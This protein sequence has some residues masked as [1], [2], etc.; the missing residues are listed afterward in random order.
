MR[1]PMGSWLLL[2]AL[3]LGPMMSASAAEV[4][5]KPDKSGSDKATSEAGSDQS[6]VAK[7]AAEK[8]TTKTKTKKKGDPAAYPIQCSVTGGII[9]TKTASVVPPP[10]PEQLRAYEVLRRE[11]EAFSAEAQDFNAR[12]TTIVRHHYEERRRAILAEIDREID[13]EKVGLNDARDEAIRRLEAFVAR[14]DGAD[15]DPQATPDAMFR[16]AALYEE[17]A[18]AGSETDLGPLLDPAIRLYLQVA[19][20]FP[21]Y[22]ELGAVLYY[23]GHALNDAARIEEAQQAFR[24]LVCSNRYHVRGLVGDAPKLALE[25]LVQDRPETFWNDWYNKNPVPFDQ[26]RNPG[27]RNDVTARDEELIFKDPYEGCAAV[28]EQDIIVGQEPR[29]LAEVW[30]QIGNYHFDQLSD[31]GPYELN[32]AAS[33]YQNSLQF[34]KPPLYGVALYK[35][36]W[37]QFKQQRY[38]TAVEQFVRLLHYADEQEKMTGDPGADFRAEA[39]TYIAGSLT[40][41]DFD[42][43][44]AGDPFIARSDALDLERDPFVAEEKMAV[45]IERLQDP[46]LIPQ[47]RKWTVEIYKAL[48]Q[49][50]V[51]LNQNRNAV[52]VLE[53]TA[54]KFPLDR[55]APVIVNRIAELYDLQARLLPL[56]SPGREELTQKALMARTELSKF[57]GNTPWTEANRDDP[58]ALSQAEDLVRTGL[59]RAAADHTNFGRAYKDRALEL[60][61]PAA[62][63]D[64]LE[65]AVNEYELAASGWAGYLAQDESAP[66]AYESHFWLADALFWAAVLKVPLGIKPTDKEI[67]DARLAASKVRDSNE[68]DRYEQPAA[69]YVVTLAERVLDVNALLFDETE[70]VRGKPRRTAVEFSGTG[71]DRKVLKEKLPSEVEAA[72]CARDEYNARIPLAKDPQKNGLMYAVQAAEYF[73]VYGQFAEARRRLN[74]IYDAYCGQNEWGYAAWEKLISMSNFEGNAA[75]SRRLVE[76]RSCA[77]DEQSSFA[78]NAIR[79]PVRQGVAYLE[80]RQ[81]FDQAVAMKDG[82]EREAQ[83]RKAAAAYQVALEAAPDREDA[84]EAAMNAAY[85]YKQVGEYEKAIAAYGLFIE[86]YGD[87]KTLTTL[88]TDSPEQYQERIKYLEEAYRAKASAYVLFFDYPMAAKTFDA[89]ASTTHF[90]RENRADAARQ[91]LTLYANLDDRAGL[92]RAQ[93]AYVELGAS[94]ESRAEAAYLVASATLK[95]WDPESPDTGANKTARLAALAAMDKYYAN[96]KG[97]RGAARFVVRAAY[98]VA[99]AYEIGKS[100]SARDSW[101]RTVTAF[102]TYVAEAPKKSGVST[103]LGSEE[104]SM[105]AEAEYRELDLVLRA[106]FDYDSGFHRYKGTVV[107]VTQ[108][109]AKDV[110]TAKGYYDKLGAIV[111]KYASQKWS[112]IAI[113]RQGSVYDSLRT[114]LYNTRPPELK[115]FT[116]EQEKALQVAEQS[117]DDNLIDK[118]DQI[119]L[120]VSEAW[121]N[122]R[123]LE[124]DGADKIVVDRYATAVLLARRYN[125]SD[126]SLTRAIRR[127]AFLSDVVGEA[128]MTT[129]TASIKD[130]GYQAGMFQRMRPGLVQRPKPSELPHP[131]PRVVP[132]KTATASPSM[133]SSAKTAFDKGIRAYD[134]GDLAGAKTQLKNAISKDQKAAEAHYALGVVEERLG[135]SSAATASYSQALAVAPGYEPALQG[136]ALLV[137]RKSGGDAA[138]A[139]L[140]A[141]RAKAPNSAPVLSALAEVQSMAGRSGDA[142]KLAQ[143]AL[144]REPTFQPAMVS[145][146]RDHYRQRRIDLALYTLQGILDGYGEGNPPRDN[147]NAEAYYLRGLIYAERAMRGP[148]MADLEKAASLRP[149]LA[150]AHFVLAAFMLEA[151]NAKDALPHL[152]MAARFDA[153]NPKLRA[154]LGDAYRLRD[155]PKDAKNELEWALSADPTDPNPHYS[156]GLLFLMSNEIPGMTQKTAADRA[157]QHFETYK[158]KVP[159]GGA[160]DVDEL[161]TRAKTKKALLEAN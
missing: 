13:V 76:G 84:P 11:V 35:Q 75:E 73:F 151:G 133:S 17:R 147:K 94:D 97:K 115:M 3:A 1:R 48:A 101:K 140:E 20:R 18:R 127:L 32:R 79:T 136:D 158:Q 65:R 91:A 55:D 45:A 57:V 19:E 100:T 117:G 33:A 15:A 25:N 37:T 93:K 64:L 70:G 53:L 86:K 160:D 49:E 129:Y 138:I 72:I 8:T 157:I 81:L 87:N 66:D 149:D 54:Q 61:D 9:E 142:Q 36:A 99:L 7:P 159:R 134:K 60:S 135:S 118:A 24:S 85:A 161:L 156:L 107:E 14:Y 104:A 27:N 154:M 74:P 12:L 39:Y 128:K 44:P 16:L 122:K 4:L 137:A 30:W 67:E 58:E 145:L 43:P 109:Y 155:R 52:A 10:T 80:A 46:D 77:F 34:K 148:A 131:S 68:D 71:S 83:W 6:A 78:E 56:G 69:Y 26:L 152:E 108:Q 132:S 102:T 116:A 90:A 106:S 47:D 111:D 121:R 113:A 123:D 110:T 21:G 143:D 82:P 29:Y 42:G 144:K 95:K 59:Q 63:K 153:K 119:R 22:K 88:K 105:A 23:L 124:L 5:S 31:G 114:G 141:A 112:A 89:I 50:F 103:A 2:G 92:E 120:Q 51:E 125:V 98:Y 40:Y 146:A 130:L 150:D 38:L 126:P 62:Q 139:R 96:Y 28:P 41:V